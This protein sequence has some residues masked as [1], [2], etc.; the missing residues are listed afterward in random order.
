MA[1]ASIG[2]EFATSPQKYLLGVTDDQYDAVVND[3]FR[4]Y[5]GAII[6]ATTNPE[7]GEKP[8]FGQLA[9]GNIP[10]LAP[11]RSTAFENH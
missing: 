4:Q 8:S 2:L 1:N 3:K 5:V 11:G 10:Q 9:Q 6:A 7:T